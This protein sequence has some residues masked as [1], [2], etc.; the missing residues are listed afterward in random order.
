M[1]KLT[2]L[3]TSLFF[4]AFSQAEK[5]GDDYLTTNEAALIQLINDYRVENGKPRL[6]I[7]KSL[8]YVARWHIWDA[9]ANNPFAQCGTQN[10]HSWSNAKPDLWTGM[11]YTKDHSQAQQ[12][13]DKPK[14]VTKGKYQ[15]SGYENAVWA[16]P[17]LSPQYAFELWKDSPGH[18]DLML[19]QGVFTP[20]SFKV[21][22]IG[23]DQGYAFAWF[24]QQ[25]DPQGSF[26]TSPGSS[27]EPPLFADGFE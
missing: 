25:S 17:S 27:G 10:L 7:S 13:W 20:V 16:Y 22:G 5:I 18:N 2:L 14:Q 1:K 12:M 19:E 11:C 21:I 4:L 15:G 6:V 24:G 8:T 3:L 26:S 23:I 9:V